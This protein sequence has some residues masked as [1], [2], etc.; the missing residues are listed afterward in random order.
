MQN[1]PS[2]TVGAFGGDS[3]NWGSSNENN[4][5][6]AK[7]GGENNFSFYAQNTSIVSLFLFLS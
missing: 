7:N 6:G 2:P 1:F 4:Q 3:F 5:V